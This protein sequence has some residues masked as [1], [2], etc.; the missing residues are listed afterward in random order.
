MG[1]IRNLVCVMLLMGSAA[2]AMA[3]PY[4]GVVTFG[5]M[6]LPGATVTATQGDKKLTAVTDENG[7]YQF[8]DLA[9]GA[10]TIDVEMQCFEKMESQV[11]VAAA[12]P[13]AT[14]E[15]KLLPQDKLVAA[16]QMAKPLEALPP[17]PAPALVKP[18][19]GQ[20]AA[21]GTGNNAPTEIPKAPEEN[22]QSADGFLVQGS[23]N[24]AATSQYATNAAFGNT[25]AGSKGLYTGGFVASEE[26]SALDARPFSLSG[27]KAA[28]PA[29][30]DFT[31]FAMVQGPFKIPHL[32]PRGPNFTCNTNG[33]ATAAR[34]S[35]RGW[36]R[37]RPSR[38]AT[39]RG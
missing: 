26:N 6:P 8:D 33:R 30:N 20:Q 4:R 10:W 9:D 24:N 28:K 29:Y 25:R 1:F 34:V 37:R 38:A 19:T 11:T 32:L 21:Q 23:V 31:G 27:V 7:A 14:F 15:L 22:E 12:M 5:G 3:S 16:S 13:A 18:P 2:L 35:I 39:L 36:C 17:A